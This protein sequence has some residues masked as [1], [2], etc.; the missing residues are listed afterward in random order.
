MFKHWLNAYVRM[1]GWPLRKQGSFVGSLDRGGVA[2]SPSHG[3]VGAPA[4]VGHLGPHA[5]YRQA[6]NATEV[7]VAWLTSWLASVGALT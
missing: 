3:R 1:L 2:A 6:L 5:W 7:V 4:T